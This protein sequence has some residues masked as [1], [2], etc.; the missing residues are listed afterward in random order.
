MEVG[1]GPNWDCSAKGKKTH[2][3]LRLTDNLKLTKYTV[4]EPGERSR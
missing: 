4:E 1:Q 3:Y 2:A